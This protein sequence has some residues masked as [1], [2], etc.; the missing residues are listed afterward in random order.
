MG[1]GVRTF[2]INE[3][4]SP[5]RLSMA[6][7]N[8]LLRFDKRET[9]PEY[10]GKRIRCAMAVLEMAG[11]RVRTIRH[12]DCFILPFDR[13]GRI[14]RKEWTRGVRLALELLPPVLEG[15]HPKQ[16]IDARYRFTKR[17]Y[18]HEFK[19]KPIR[20]MEEGIVATIFGPR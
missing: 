10:G 20:K 1:I 4:D 7:L 9:L 2:L 18:D 15:A 19:W 17:R 8:R 11:R 16:V 3:N 13:K 14:D 5:Q 12:I 6:R